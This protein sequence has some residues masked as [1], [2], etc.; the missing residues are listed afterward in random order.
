[1]SANR[2]MNKEDVVHVYNGILLSFKNNEIMVFAATWMD[3]EI[4]YYISQTEKDKHPMASH[5][6]VILNKKDTN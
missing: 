5:K 2:G 4:S 1:M 3:L 6:C